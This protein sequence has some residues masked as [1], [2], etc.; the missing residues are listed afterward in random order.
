MIIVGIDPSSQ[1]KGHG[2][3]TYKDNKLCSLD[4][5]QRIRLINHLLELKKDGLIVAIENNLD[6]G[7]YRKPKRNP[8]ESF[9]SWLRR[10]QKMAQDIG[11][12]KQTQIELMRD[13]DY[14]DMRFDLKKQSSRWK[15][16]NEFKLIT[17]WDKQSNEDTRSAAYFGYLEFQKQNVVY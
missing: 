6:R 1:E 4:M 3:A 16:G 5:M 12:L 9:E 7:V 11:K 2:V 15:K 17:G 14:Y 10:C 13:L 8:G